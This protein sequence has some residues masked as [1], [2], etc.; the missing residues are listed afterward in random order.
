[1]VPVLWLA[2]SATSTSH[3][4][5]A[6]STRSLRWLIA[7]SDLVI[8]GR[9]IAVEEMVAREGA[10]PL[11]RPVLRVEVLE[12]LKGPAVDGKEL[13]FAQHG[14][15]VAEYRPNDEA[16]FFLRD[17][18]R[19]P[20]L[21]ELRGT[22]KVKWYSS[23]EHDDDYVLSPQSRRVTLEAARAYVAIE[24][25]PAGKRAEA[26]RRI[27]VK[28]LASR[29][30][31]LSTSA[32]RDLVLAGHAPLVAKEDIPALIKVID[33]SRTSIGVRVGLLAELE[34]RRLLEG[35][36]QWM[37]LLRTTKRADR[38]AV[39]RAA[40]AHPSPAVNGELAAILM[41]PDGAAAAAA[42]ISLGS[43]GNTTAVGPLS[44]AAASENTRIAMAA[45]R[46]LGKVGSAEA[47]AALASIVAS[48]PDASV[49]R[50]AQAELRLFEARAP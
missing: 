19:S 36:P 20:E 1:M 24:K 39:I 12:V 47:R 49:R 2:V 32:L 43:P 35:D 42:A 9:P 40:G 50:R 22:G 38:L 28:L 26:L 8:R 45:I 48:H 3:G 37:R 29:D 11:H 7:D 23:Q 25:T 34:R 4:H 44:K 14:H 41:R 6:V 30:L 5:I 18:S 31:R 27:T 15:G 46:G 13:R 10:E 16:L 17:L 21:S 33:D